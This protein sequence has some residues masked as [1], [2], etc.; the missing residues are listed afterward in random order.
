[1]H[2]RYQI[3]RDQSEQEMKRGFFEQMQQPFG[4]FLKAT[5]ANTALNMGEKNL[6][7][8]F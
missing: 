5:A 1:M 7:T 2:L 6:V 4:G 3:Y 8:A